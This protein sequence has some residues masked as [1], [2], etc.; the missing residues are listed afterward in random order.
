MFPIVPA[1]WSAIWSERPDPLHKQVDKTNRWEGGRGFYFREPN[2]DNL[3]VLTRPYSLYEGDQDDGA[4]Q[5][6]DAGSSLV[7]DPFYR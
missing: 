2:G 6:F 3:E 5:S 4:N 7:P 1:L